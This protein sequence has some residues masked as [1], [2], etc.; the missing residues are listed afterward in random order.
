MAYLFF[1]SSY[2][3]VAFTL[4]SWHLLS[5][6]RKIRPGYIPAACRTL[7]SLSKCGGIVRILGFK[8]C[9]ATL[10]ARGRP[11]FLCTAHTFLVS[12]DCMVTSISSG[13]A[14]VTIAPTCLPSVTISHLKPHGQLHF[15]DGLGFFRPAD[16]D[17]LGL[18]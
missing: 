10:I 8:F 16:A 13:F 12:S 6:C 4:S 1:M 18:P 14:T 2:V 17:P 15:L 9:S 5:K 7:A 11:F 3:K